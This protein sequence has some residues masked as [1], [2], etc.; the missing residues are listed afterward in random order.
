MAGFS[1][2]QRFPANDPLTHRDF[3]LLWSTW[4]LN[5]GRHNGEHGAGAPLPTLRHCERS[6]AIQRAAKEGWIASSLRSS[7]C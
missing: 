4:L 2:A 1:D 5:P 3:C 7:Q 6:K